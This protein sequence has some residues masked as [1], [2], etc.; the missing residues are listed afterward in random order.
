MG[1][2]FMHSVDFQDTRKQTNKQKKKSKTRCR[3]GSYLLGK[4]ICK[5]LVPVGREA[6]HCTALCSF[7]T[8][9]HINDF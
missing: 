9:K 3:G 6:L 4:K 5:T 8:S 2:I 7:W 1:Q